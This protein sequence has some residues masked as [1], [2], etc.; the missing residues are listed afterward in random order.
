MDTES[1]GASL[2]A[3]AR[4]KQAKK[5]SSSPTGL[6]SKFMFQSQA[7]ES[8]VAVEVPRSFAVQASC[9][10][11]GLGPPRPRGGRQGSVRTSCL[12]GRF[13]QL[14]SFLWVSTEP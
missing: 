12:G 13:Y 3:I 1:S 11:L 5:V 14:G 8:S 4:N 10:L 6:E 9:H 7:V 2:P